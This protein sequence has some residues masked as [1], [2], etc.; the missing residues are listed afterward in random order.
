MIHKWT[1]EGLTP[2][3]LVI[4]EILVILVISEISAI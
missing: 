3:I 1:N 2:V 4:S